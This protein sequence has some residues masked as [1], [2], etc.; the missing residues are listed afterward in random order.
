MKFESNCQIHDVTSIVFSWRTTI[1]CEK[2]SH[3]RQVF[4]YMGIVILFI[5]TLFSLNMKGKDINSVERSQFFPECMQ[6]ERTNIHV[7]L[8]VVGS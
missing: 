3:E 7:Y 6:L 2:L 1:N 8:Y 5:I 4:V